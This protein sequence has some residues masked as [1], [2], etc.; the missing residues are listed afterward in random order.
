M[1][2]V[3]R[4]HMVC[5]HYQPQQIDRNIVNRIVQHTA[6]TWQPDRAAAE[7]GSNT[8]QGKIAE[9]MVEQFLRSHF[10]GKLSILAYDEIRNDDFQKHAPFDFL[11]WKTGTADM[12]PIV[13]AVRRDITNSLDEAVRLSEHTRQLCQAANVKIAEIK[14]TKIR[15]SLKEAAGFR[16]D[17]TDEASVTRLLRTIRNTDDVFCYPHYKRSEAAEYSQG[18]YCN[19]VKAREPSLG[20]YR[21]ELLKSKVMET[22][23]EKQCCDIFIR[24][25]LDLQANRGFVIGWMQKEV[26]LDDKACFK[27]MPQPGKSEKALYFAKKLSQ[28][29]GM[30]QIIRVFAKEKDQLSRISAQG[31][32]QPPQI[33]AHDRCVYANP[34]STRNFY[35]KSIACRFLTRVRREDILFFQNEEAAIAGGRFTQRCRECFGE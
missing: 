29:E 13:A 34:D 21:G 28:T 11:I 9:E 27:R 18:D 16:G 19:M 23:A 1:D 7:R 3:L 32:D 22:E 24:V 4:E 26:L 8:E 10:E 25:Y 31:K 35:H 30:D 12:E 14:S 33:S 2:F 5:A 6:E 20:E 15:E 17:Y